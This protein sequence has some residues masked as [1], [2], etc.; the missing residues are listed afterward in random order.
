MTDRRK[1]GT[2][3]AAALL[4]ASSTLPAMAQTLEQ[5]FENPAKADRPRLRWWWPGAAVDPAE[6]DRELAL[7]DENGFAGGEI[8]PFALGLDN[9]TPDQRDAVNDYAEPRFWEILRGLGKTAQDR[10]M[11]LDYTFGSAW[12]SGGGF[13]VTPELAM[14]ELAMARTEIQGGTGKSVKVAIPARTRRLGALNPQDPRVQDPK[15]ADWAKRM[16][17][18]AHVVAVVAMK[19]DA[20]GTKDSGAPAGFR[21]FPWDDVVQPGRLDPVSHVVLTD[22]LRPDGTLDWAPPPGKWQVLVFKQYAADMGVMASAGKGPQLVIDHMRPDAFAVHAARVGDR[23]GDRPVGIR[24]TFVDSLEL[25]QDMPWTPDFL[26]QFRKRRGYD[27]TPYLP[28]I[29]QPGWMQA[30]GEHYSPP[31]FDATG[32][33]A[34]ERVRADYRRTVSD[35]M[36]EGFVQPFVA[37]N[38]AHGLKARFQAHGGAFD[39]IRGYGLA[40]IPETEDLVDGADP[41]FMRLARSAAHL[42]GHPLISA[43]SLVWKDRPFDV[44]PQEMRQRVDLII[45]GGV[46]S[47]VLHGMNYR[48]ETDKWPGWY[49]FSPSGFVMGFSGALNEN[50]PIWP[51][52][53]SLAGYIARLQGVMQAGEAVVPVAYFYGG[54][55]YY[56]GIED[57]GAARFA[58]EKGFLAAGYDYDRINPDAIADARVEG[59]QLVA[60]GGQRY[61]VLVLPPIDGIRADT[62]E[63]IARFAHA[64]LPVIFTDRAPSRD[65]GLADAAAR[66]GRVTR[67]V[68]DAIAAGARIVPA[69]QVAAALRTA[70]I[71]PNLRFEGDPADIVYVQRRIDGRTAT[72]LFNHGGTRRDVTLTLPG[73]GSV[74]RWNGMDG[75]ITPLSAQ[76]VE[77][78]ARLPLTLEAGESAL[79]MLDPAGAPQTSA[80][81]QTAARQALPADGWRLEAKGHVQRLPFAQD[82][83]TVT[84]KDWKNVPELARFAGSA[85]YSRSV[86]ID[87]AW[88]KRGGHVWLDLGQVHDMATVSVNGRQLPPVIG[89]PFRMDLTSALKSGDNALAIT[90]DNVAQNSMIDPAVAGYDKLKPVAAGLVGP[91]VLES[92]R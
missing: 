8:Q 2:M 1:L 10:G 67:A 30:W 63:A 13:T 43:E 78:G 54:Y 77:A 3:L 69:A 47:L 33:V 92:V 24:S 41:Y 82:L 64:G 53:K 59:G 81:P 20:P 79:L 4:A 75:S 34:G 70:N 91:V 14:V 55:G 35:L 36:I 74:S 17:D 52:I 39:I 65:E 85:T 6:L 61:P 37:W 21:L 90:V 62:A 7:M 68:A 72:F 45:S 80:N 19:G 50:N 28:F 88:L 87:P 60:K 48:R 38:H 16:D 51:A 25:M 57:E 5:R 71:A 22:K 42:Y 56:P 83:G 44:T 89:A 46:N 32:S 40:D 26:D 12:P 76:A 15:V 31:Y 84:L 58:A 66:D 49:P 73:K 23:L 18:R 9:L 11:T 27:L 29:L 86:R